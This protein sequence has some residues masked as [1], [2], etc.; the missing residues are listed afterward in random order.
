MT[1]A[2][3][4]FFIPSGRIGRKTWWMSMIALIV[5]TTVL[6]LAVWMLEGVYRGIPTDM[7]YVNLWVQG[8]SPHFWWSPYI[9]LVL[10]AWSGFAINTKRFH[11]HDKSAWWNLI[12]LIYVA[13]V[14]VGSLW[15]A[16]LG[17]LV[18]SAMLGFFAGDDVANKYGD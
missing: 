16:V 3:H 9:S 2:L 14:L 10:V 12:N 15:L 18:Q 4:H 7:F 8:F 5:G 11:D 6:D 1:E 13:G 17:L